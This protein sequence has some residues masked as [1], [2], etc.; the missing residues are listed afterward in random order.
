MAYL[1]L[2]KE[3][4]LISDSCGAVTLYE[5]VEAPN[6]ILLGS[7]SVTQKSY[8]KG[9]DDKLMMPKTD[10]FT[11][12]TNEFLMKRVANDVTLTLQD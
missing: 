4:F 11:Y 1:D 10:R 7:S 12:V 3:A 2:Y 9:K 8:S 5:K 6:M